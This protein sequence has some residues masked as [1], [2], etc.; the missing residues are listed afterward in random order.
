MT[1]SGLR[2][3]TD[4]TMWFLLCFM[5]GTGLLIHYRLVPGAEGGHGL[6]LLG[7]SRHEWGNYHLWAA[8]LLLFCLS[9]HL[10]LNYSFIKNKIAQ[11]MNWR[12]MLLCCGGLII[13]GAFLFAP[14][15]KE[16]SDQGKG[17]NHQTR[18]TL[19]E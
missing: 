8:Y 17:R 1:N 18:Q 5:L 10:F 15:V 12:V 14:I 16:E 13:V 6:T 11:K 2:K 19:Q 4:L 7:L 3:A 9:I